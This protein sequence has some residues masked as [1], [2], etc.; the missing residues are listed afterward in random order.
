MKQVLSEIKNYDIAFAGLKEGEYCFDFEINKEF[1]KFFDYSEIK[2]TEVKVKLTLTKRHS[3]LILDF[4]LR[5][6]V[7]LNCDRCNRAYNQLINNDFHLI[8][9]FENDIID[10]NSDDDIIFIPRADCKINIASFIYEYVN[11]ALPMRRVHLSE[12]DCDQQIINK[13]NNISEENT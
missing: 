6:T 2:E 11:L 1:F 13:L 7:N 12:E 3:F 5:G 9:K 4:N 10:D 8:V